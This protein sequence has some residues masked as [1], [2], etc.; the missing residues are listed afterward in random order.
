MS[1]FVTC[2]FG[3][4]R[5]ASEDGKFPW[6][7]GETRHDFLSPAEAVLRM[8]EWNSNQPFGPG[9]FFFYWLKEVIERDGLRRPLA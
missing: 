1:A 4:V 5:G 8:R 9:Q 6:G 2:V 3:F 7:V